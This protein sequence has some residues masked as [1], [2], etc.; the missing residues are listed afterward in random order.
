MRANLPFAA[1]AILVT[2]LAACVGC[3]SNQSGS[4]SNIPKGKVRPISKAEIEAAGDAWEAFVPEIRGNVPKAVDFWGKLPGEEPPLDLEF[5]DLGH[6]TILPHQDSVRKPD[7]GKLVETAK[8]KINARER[9]ASGQY[10]QMEYILHFTWNGTQWEVDGA[11]ALLKS[12]DD[13]SDPNINR[14]LS[15]N[16]EEIEKYKYFNALLAPDEPEEDIKK[17]AAPSR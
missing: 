1:K 16:A 12:S 14:P 3:P 11:E 13:A 8:L 9:I 17:D 4:S 5:T 6:E 7:V 2:S 10:C 15:M